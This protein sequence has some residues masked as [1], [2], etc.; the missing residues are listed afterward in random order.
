MVEHFIFRILVQFKKYLYFKGLIKKHNQCFL[1]DMHH[2][3]DTIS[4][5]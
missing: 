1:F 5:I 3:V 2:T 4:Q